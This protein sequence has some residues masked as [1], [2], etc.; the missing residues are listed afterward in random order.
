MS[1]AV[2]ESLT[3]RGAPSP[4]KPVAVK[5]QEP[6]YPPALVRSNLTRADSP[7]P[8]LLEAFLKRKTQTPPESGSM[9][10]WSNPCG[11]VAALPL[12]AQRGKRAGC[13]RARARRERACACRARACPC[14][15]GRWD[16]RDRSGTSAAPLTPPTPAENCLPGQ[17][18]WPF[19]SLGLQAL[20]AARVRADLMETRLRHG[21]GNF[22]N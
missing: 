14:A 21:A 20:C 16:H 12:A 10:V 11:G 6:L 15:C 7:G 4:E 19:W 1:S 8:Q 2:N 17:L 5:G 22:G 18:R 13:V 3:E 9:F